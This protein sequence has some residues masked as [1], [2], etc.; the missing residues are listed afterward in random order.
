MS[1]FS[2]FDYPEIHELFDRLFDELF[3]E[4]GRGAIL[5]ST[6]Y[7]EQHLTKLVESVLPAD[8]SKKD[9]DRLFSYPGP[10]S[11]FAAKISLSYA[12]RIIDKNLYD[13]LNALRSVRNEAAHSPTAF[14]LHEL[15]DRMKNVYN[16]GPSIPNHIRKQAT[17]AMMSLKFDTLNTVFDEHNLTEEERREQVKRILDKPETIETLEKQVPYYELV[18]GLCF[19]CGVMS[20]QREK[21]LSLTKLSTTWEGLTRFMSDEASE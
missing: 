16:L 12:F 18:C 1:T 7:V 19:V 20:Y 17:E 21:L 6:T 13:S 11:S 10:L 8:I 14:S 2:P 4:S 3:K 15:N 9:K 5:I